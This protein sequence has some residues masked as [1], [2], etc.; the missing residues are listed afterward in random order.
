MPQNNALYDVPLTKVSNKLVPHGFISEIILPEIKVAQTSGKIANYGNGHLRIVNTVHIGRGGY[1]HVESTTRSD[2][3]YSIEDHGLEGIITKRDKSN[4]T[5]PYDAEI[6]K[7]DELTTHLWLGKEKSL[8]D[9]LQNPAII[10]QGATLA[11][12]AQYNNIGHADSNPLEDL[13]T[14]K[15]VMLDAIGAEPNVGIMGRKTFNALRSHAE[16]IDSF[17]FKYVRTGRLSEQELASALDLDFIHV[18]DAVYN[19][20]NQGQADVIA[21]VWGK[22]VIYAKIGKPA[23]RQK[24][25]GFEVSQAGTLKRKVNKWDMN[26]PIGAKGI[27]V[28]DNYDQLILNAECAYLIQDAIA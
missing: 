12:N 25:L 16:I 6:D 7:T 13:L 20:A 27:A 4:V 28:S 18:G 26:S 21:P 10:T 19:S 11:G 9:T 17:G 24:V 23:L 2:D 3:S 5:R 22:D 1:A 8:A 14:A 15:G